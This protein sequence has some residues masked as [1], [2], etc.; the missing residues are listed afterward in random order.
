MYNLLQAAV[1]LN[2]EY[3]IPRR[4]AGNFDKGL[5]TTTKSQH[6]NI[7]CPFFLKHHQVKVHFSGSFL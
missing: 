1:R 2:L 4:V 5:H 3:H 6:L 7:K